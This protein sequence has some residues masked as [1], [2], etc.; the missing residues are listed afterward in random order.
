MNN[1]DLIRVAAIVPAVLLTIAAWPRPNHDQAKVVETAG[2]A[3]I[4]N[5]ATATATVTG[6]DTATRVL[7]L[8]TRSGKR[9]NY[10]AGPD[11]VNFD[12]IEIGDRVKAQVREETAISIGSGKA[13]ADTSAGRVALAPVGAKP[14]GVMMPP[15]KGTVRIVS[16]DAKRHSVT[17]LLADGSTQTVKA[18]KVD[19]SVLKRG[20]DVTIQVVKGVLLAVRKP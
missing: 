4:V 3:I 17:Y 10:Q 2:G 8:V 6:I 14:G 15:A 9:I 18:G 5:P 11:I 12:L 1:K 19:V 20:D 16:V 13:Q 7:T